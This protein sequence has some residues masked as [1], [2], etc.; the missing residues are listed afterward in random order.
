MSI[1]FL[2]LLKEKIIVFD[3]AMGTS[4]QNYPLSLDDFIGKDG[5]NEILV[6][7]KPEIIKELESKLVK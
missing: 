1:N 2:D 4:I 6:N 5:C 3:G 7:T